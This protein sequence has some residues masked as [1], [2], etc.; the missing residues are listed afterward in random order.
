[1]WTTTNP[2]RPSP[3][4]A[5]THFLPTADWYRLSGHGHRRAVRGRTG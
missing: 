3:V 4:T 1:M 2:T 5:M